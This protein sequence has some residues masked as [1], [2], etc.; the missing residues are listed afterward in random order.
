MNSTVQIRADI[1]F[2]KF[3]EG[4]MWDVSQKCFGRN[5]GIMEPHGTILVKKIEITETQVSM[6]IC[7]RFLIIILI[8]GH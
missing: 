6:N 7:N 5:L 8:A 2:V 4:E 1:E 3:T